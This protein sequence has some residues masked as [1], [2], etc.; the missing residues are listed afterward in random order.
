MR[1]T[2]LSRFRAVRLAG[3]AR[4]QAERSLVCPPEP[5]LDGKVA[6]VTGGNAGIGYETCRGLL[7]RGAEVVMA[8]RDA[9][10]ARAACERLVAD[11]GRGAR[12]EHLPL[13]L[14]DLESVA[15][16]TD[17]LGSRSVDLLVANAGVWPRAPG[18]S[19]QGHEAA[20]AVNV[21]GH[22]L[23]LR[24]LLGRVPVGGRVVVLTG[25]IYCLARHCTPD[26]AYRGRLGGGLAYCRSKLGDLWLVTELA[27]RHPEVLALAVHPGIVS[28]SLGGRR[29][30]AG[31]ES[32]RGMEIDPGAG[33][34]TTLFCATQPGLR[35]GGY[36]HNVYGL[37]DLPASDPALDRAG[38]RLLWETCERL[39]ATWLPAQPAAAAA[40][41]G[42]AAASSSI[43]DQ[44]GDPDPTRR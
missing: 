1:E 14:G 17:R 20:F 6:L 8:S 4:K 32:R 43:C 35:P 5:R 11:L 33:A 12:V 26:Y 37:V 42:R 36:Y 15:R 38:A 13:D 24:R 23:L 44:L 30:S 19:A 10:K 21:L 27:R 22:F 7:E 28:T 25:D 39:A 41:P 34:Q 3:C 2:A 9:A 29:E 31:S 18:P 40:D 16:A